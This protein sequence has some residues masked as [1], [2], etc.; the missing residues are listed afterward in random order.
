MKGGDAS[1][2]EDTTVFGLPRLTRI[3]TAHYGGAAAGPEIPLHFVVSALI[4]LPFACRRDARP[5]LTIGC[6]ETALLITTSR[7]P[8]PAVHRDQAPKSCEGSLDRLCRL[9]VEPDF[10]R[11]ASASVLRAE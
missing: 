2:G 5:R 3:V 8:V 1:R 7:A 11:L 9:F 6:L 4:S 10:G